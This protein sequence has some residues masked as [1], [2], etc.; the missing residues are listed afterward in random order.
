MSAFASAE[1]EAK[2]NKPISGVFR[3]DISVREVPE[4]RIRNYFC[5]RIAVIKGKLR[6]LGD[7]LGKFNLGEQLATVEC[8]YRNNCH[9]GWQGSLLEIGAIFKNGN[10][11]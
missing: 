11:E 2:A 3:N 6:N 5:E 7:A 9:V 1:H 4:R 8:A 10:S